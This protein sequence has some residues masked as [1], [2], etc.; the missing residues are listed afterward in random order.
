MTIETITLIGVILTF[1]VTV[2]GWV[3]TYRSQKHLIRLQEQF[4]LDRESRQYT[5]PDKM[6]F[7]NRVTEWFNQ[8]LKLA[9]RARTLI[10]VQS[11]P[12]DQRDYADEKKTLELNHDAW[13]EQQAQN[14]IL[15]KTHDPKFRPGHYWV[16]GSP[17]LPSDLPNLILAFGFYVS[18]TVQA[19]SQ[20][21]Y[22]EQPSE[23]KI[24]SLYRAGMDA[25]ERVKR[26]LMT[27]SKK[28]APV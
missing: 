24:T 13:Q 5:L 21:I 22:M 26:L 2:I 12:G 25:T 7:P 10:G 1:L 28:T 23:D 19:I 17:A 14:F 3:I 20:D 16:L 27:N 11:L 8:G 15:A 18:V 9:I 6:E 4:T